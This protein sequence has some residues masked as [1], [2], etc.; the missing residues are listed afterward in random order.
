M[1]SPA[2]FSFPSYRNLCRYLGE[3]DAMV[4]L[5]ELAARSFL[6]AARESGDPGAYVREASAKHNVCVNLPEV[7]RLSAHLSQNYIVTVYQSAERFLHEFRREHNALF[8]RQWGNDRVDADPLTVT[9]GNVATTREVAEREIGMD[10]ISRFQY[11]RLVR[12]AI[13][14]MKDSGA[15]KAIVALEAIP[16]Y[17][18]DNV[19]RY[20]R[21]T[22]PNA[23][24]RLTFDDFVLFSRITKAVAERLC[25]LATPTDEDFRRLLQSDL[26][27]FKR[28]ENKPARMVNAV[29]CHLRTIY[30]LDE[31][32]AKW[33][34]S[35]VCDL[36]HERV[37]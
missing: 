18:P 13:V 33:L 30:G 9:L 7:A 28:F 19:A 24:D 22:A 17:A 21:T 6:A 35:G 10:L 1:T 25:M 11:Y 14:H 31:E 37:G 32:T 8:Q 4:E 26:K 36:A 3:A 12:N 16:P 23:P 20:G 27:R 15:K 5:T 2:T 29:S 34:A